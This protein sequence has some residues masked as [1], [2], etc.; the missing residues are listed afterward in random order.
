MINISKAVRSLQLLVMVSGIVGT[1]LQ[2]HTLSELTGPSSVCYF[3]IFIICVVIYLT[4]LY[5]IR[6]F[7]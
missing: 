2:V 1:E 6:S 4:L 5:S 3:F 7:G